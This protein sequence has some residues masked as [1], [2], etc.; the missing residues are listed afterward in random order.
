[1]FVNDTIGYRMSTEQILFY[2]E[3]AFGTTDAISIK[4]NKLRI[5]DLK[6]G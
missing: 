3:N 1:M 2:S 4:G 5:H 6:T